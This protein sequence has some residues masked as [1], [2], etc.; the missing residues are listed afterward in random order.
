MP[1]PRSLLKQGPERPDPLG[2]DGWAWSFI[3]IGIRQAE[4]EKEL[5]GMT[6]AVTRKRVELEQEWDAL[7]RIKEIVP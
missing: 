2:R 4:I 1:D 7:E 6:L 5:S 3:S